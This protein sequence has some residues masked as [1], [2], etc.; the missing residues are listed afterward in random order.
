MNVRLN[1]DVVKESIGDYRY[2]Y[3]QIPSLE[4]MLNSSECFSLQLLLKKNF[5]LKIQLVVHEDVILT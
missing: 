4:F 3:N 5:K 2:I 1:M